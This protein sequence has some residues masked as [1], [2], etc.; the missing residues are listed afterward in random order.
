MR[1]GVL[2]VLSRKRLATSRKFRARTGWD[3]C[4]DHVQGNSQAAGACRIGLG[5]IENKISLE[6]QSQIGVLLGRSIT[7]RI[8]D[9]SVI[10]ALEICEPKAAARLRTDLIH[11]PA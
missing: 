8:D 6:E 9:Y 4:V 7:G 2:L 1:D 10:A 3:T 11:D 5:E